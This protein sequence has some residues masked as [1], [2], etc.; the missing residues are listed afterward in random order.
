MLCSPV[1]RR[2]TIYAPSRQFMEKRGEEIVEKAARSKESVE[3]FF[4]EIL[5]NKKY[6]FIWKDGER[7]AVMVG[8]VS[9]S[10]CCCSFYCCIQLRGHVV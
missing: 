5:G 10:S 3:V 8:L 9:F 1:D 7:H 2:A 4:V 6:Q